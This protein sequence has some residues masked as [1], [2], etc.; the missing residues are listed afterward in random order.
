M[1]TWA[2]LS[3][4]SS[5]TRI[6]AIK[7]AENP[8]GI[9]VTTRPIDCDPLKAGITREI[10]TLV[11]EGTIVAECEKRYGKIQQECIAL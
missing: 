8:L 3:L 7:P 10:V 2:K 4:D 6:I 5:L 11:F 9:S 1:H